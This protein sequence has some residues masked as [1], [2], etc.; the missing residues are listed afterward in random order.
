MEHQIIRHSSKIFLAILIIFTGWGLNSCYYDNAED[1]YPNPPTCDTT[2]ITYSGTVAPV[3]S[4][5]CNSCHSTTSASGGIITDNYDDL[6]SAVDGGRF[7]GAINQQ[8]GYS[9][10]PQ[11]GQKLNECTLAKIDIWILD[12]APNN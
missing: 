2:N 6:K 4:A 3:M 7:W 5:Y 8:P 12:G 10:M 9:P 11:G 1:L